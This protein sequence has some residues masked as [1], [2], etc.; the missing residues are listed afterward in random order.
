MSCK[1]SFFEKYNLEL[2]REYDSGIINEVEIVQTIRFKLKKKSLTWYSK[3]EQ[4]RENI[5]L[6]GKGSLKQ[7]VHIG[8]IF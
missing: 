8:P 1:F 2:Y 3:S 6:D 5:Y 7:I 4:T